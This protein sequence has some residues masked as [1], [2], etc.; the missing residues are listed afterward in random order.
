LFVV[1]SI[2][3]PFTAENPGRLQTLNRFHMTRD[4]I[5]LNSIWTSGKLVAYSNFFRQEVKLDLLTS[6]YN[7]E[8]T[9]EIISANFTQAV[10]DF[11]ALSEQ[12]KPLMQKLLYKHCLQCCESTSYGVNVLAG[13]TETAA[14]LRE[15]G[16]VDEGSA[17]EKATLDHVTIEEDTYLTNRF[18]R[19]TFY[20]E[21][22]TEHGCELILKNGELLD[23]FGESGTYLGQFEE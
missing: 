5:L 14:N 17:F 12:Y 21:W 11:L 23:Y 3:I 6:E 13:E 7:L 9:S 8:S 15:F 16:V 20:P 2:V 10:N 18:V 22:E 19:I 1:S 4:E